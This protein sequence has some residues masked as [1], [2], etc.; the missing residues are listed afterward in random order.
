MAHNHHGHD[1]TEQEI[2][3]FTRLWLANASIREIERQLGEWCT[4]N[5]M[6]GK[7]RRLGL[8]A[9]VERGHYKPREPELP[10]MRAVK[11]VFTAPVRQMAMVLPMQPAL[12]CQWL[13]GETTKTF[14]QCCRPALRPGPG[15]RPPYVY[16]AQHRDV[17]FARLRQ[18]SMLHESEPGTCASGAH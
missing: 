1:W 3:L 17:A 12:K 8:P 16:C 6:L 18:R 9:R 7:R 13:D 14:V 5:A 11:P 10:P 2:A 4:K 15:V